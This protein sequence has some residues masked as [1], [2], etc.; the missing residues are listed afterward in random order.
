MYSNKRR[1]PALLITGKYVL[2]LVLSALI[3]F[4]IVVAAYLLPTDR[5]RMYVRNNLPVLEREGDYVSAFGTSYGSQQDNYSDAYYLGQAVLDG[6]ENPVYYAMTAPAP[7]GTGTPVSDLIDYMQGSGDAEYTNMHYFWNGW[8]AV[9]KVLMQIMS[10]SEIRHLNMFLHTA[11]LFLLMRMLRRRVGAEMQFPFI[12]SVL[13]MNPVTMGLTLSFSGYYYQ[14]LI[15]CMIM[16]RYHEKLLRRNLYGMFFFLLGITAFYFNFN[17]F[18]LC[19]VGF[20][21][22]LYFSLSNET[23]TADLV[24]KVFLYGGLWLCGF[25]GMM[26]MKWVLY[27]VLIDGSIFAEQWEHIMMRT[28]AEMPAGRIS[29]FEAVAKNAVYIFKN[30]A[31]LLFEAGYLAFIAYRFRKKGVKSIR[32]RIPDVVLVIMS[33]L[34]VNGRY[35]LE[36]NHSLMHDW[37][38]YRNWAIAI[39]A[40]NTCLAKLVSASDIDTEM[41][42]D[43]AEAERRTTA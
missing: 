3:G 21:L 20:P 29:R 33:V 4:I 30:K 7:V 26:L 32:D 25:F 39:F 38:V 1:K 13:F 22:V 28:G 41:L 17:Y 9:L 8:I 16:L 35:F 23:D 10:Y 14:I 31:F 19:T 2:L 15:S 34:V 18:Q 27:A 42:H 36:A 24:K 40:F 43:N 37:V 11:L 5:I 12:L 6:R